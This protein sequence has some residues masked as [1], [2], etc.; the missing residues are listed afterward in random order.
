[1]F[2]NGQP[3]LHVLYEAI[4]LSYNLLLHDQSTTTVWKYICQA[5]SNV[6]LGRPDLFL[7]DR[8][9]AYLSREMDDLAVD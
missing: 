9:S 7:M 4:H 8:G 6:Y 5:W 2:K 3:V 1:M